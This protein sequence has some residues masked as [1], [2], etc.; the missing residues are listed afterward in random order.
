MFRVLLLIAR[1]AH[2]G[3]PCAFSRSHLPSWP[4]LVY[5]TTSLLF[6]LSADA[7]SAQQ[8]VVARQ[9]P[10]AVSVLKDVLSHAQ[11]SSGFLPSRVSIAG[12]ITT[13]QKKPVNA[14]FSL[15]ISSRKIAFSATLPGGT[16]SFDSNDRVF[17]RTI[18]G[19]TTLRLPGTQHRLWLFS[20]SE[21]AD[22]LEMANL[23]VDLLGKGESS[24]RHVAVV[25]VKEASRGTLRSRQQLQDKDAI[26]FE[27]DTDDHDVLAITDCSDPVS[28]IPSKYCFMHRMEFSDFRVDQGIRMAHRITELVGLSPEN[29]FTVDA[30]TTGN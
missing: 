21:I 30:I 10:E 28:A 3:R 14:P 11:S 6:L 4:N 26:Y 8:A 20:H 27:I 1:L 7:A 29:V 9:D 2:W 13:W 12:T 25:A 24:G 18:Q 23:N 22:L 5:W 16:V 19:K 15:H 17:S